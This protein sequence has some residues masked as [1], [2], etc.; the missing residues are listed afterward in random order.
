MS[1]ISSIYDVL[2][3]R[4]GTILPN[5]LRLPHAYAIEKNPEP[6]LKQGWALQIKGADNSPRQ[7]D[8]HLTMSREFTIVITRKFYG[9]DLATAAKASAEK[10]LMEDH[11]LMVKDLEGDASLSNLVSKAEYQSDSG[12]ELVFLGDKPFY[13]IESNINVQYREL[14]TP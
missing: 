8:C 10:D 6:S 1:K 11:L 2:V 4:V 3:T 13:K 5:H 9:S 7:V 12:I 14:I